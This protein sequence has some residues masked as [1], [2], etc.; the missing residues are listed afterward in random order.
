MEFAPK[1][2]NLISHDM[3]YGVLKYVSL[4]IT[5]KLLCSGRGYKNIFLGG[6]EYADSKIFPEA[7]FHPLSK[8]NPAKFQNSISHVHSTDLSLT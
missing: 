1:L 6:A 2:S 3:L 4:V 7:P 5:W 8:E